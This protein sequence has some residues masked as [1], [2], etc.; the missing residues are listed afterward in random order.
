MAGPKIKFSKDL[1]KSRTMDYIELYGI[2]NL[3]ARKLANYIG[4][5]TQPIFRV[6]DSME[7]LIEETYGLI[8]DK[9]N[10]IVDEEFNKAEIPFL[11][12]GIG[13]IRFSQDHPNLFKA[14]FLS[15]HYKN[16]SLASLFEG[17]ESSESIKMM[18]Q[19]IGINLKDAQILMRNIWLL[20]HGIATV[21][22]YNDIQYSKN[23]ITSILGA[24]FRG[25]IS[26]LKE[27]E[28]E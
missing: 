23:E 28:N 7:E 6:F 5:S 12:I 8:E 22:A 15:N 4:S 17:D 3:N 20:T 14:L 10:Q 21:M 25:F 19:M 2:E 27:K 1:I 16:E 13:Y 11:G 24:G 26:Q 18:S 9:Y